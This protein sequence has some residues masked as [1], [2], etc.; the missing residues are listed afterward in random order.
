MER[1]G[2]EKCWLREGR[3]DEFSQHM[4]AILNYCMSKINAALE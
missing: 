4:T 2:R 1:E 3:T